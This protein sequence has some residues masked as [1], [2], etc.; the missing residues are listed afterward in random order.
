M[1][2]ASSASTRYILMGLGV[3]EFA[4]GLVAAFYG[5]AEIYVFYFFSEGGR[6]AYPGFGM[7]SVWFAAL[8]A[9][10][11]A[12]YLLAAAL[13]PLGYATLRRRAWAARA[14]LVLA[15]L[16]LLLGILASVLVLTCAATVLTPSELWAFRDR[17]AIIGIGLA[18]V[19]VILPVLFILLFTRPATSQ[20]LSVRSPF[21]DWLD[22]QPLPL[23]LATIGCGLAIIALHL[24]VFAQVFWPMFGTLGFGRANMY[25]I[26]VTIV[27]LGLVMVGLARGKRLALWGAA[28]VFA[29]LF[30]AFVTTFWNHDLADLLA[31]MDLPATERAWVDGARL[32]GA[33]FMLLASGLPLGAMLVLLFLGRRRFLRSPHLP[34]KP[35]HPEM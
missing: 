31:A 25:P 13:L 18:V 34:L 23:L 19:A 24:M 32:P 16:W 6:F 10:N 9:H 30:L 1:P 3:V 15:W 8:V 17:M 27:A 14:T 5:P 35:V 29:V 28:A 2:D 20:V 21:G 22:E 7:G 4:I 11:L 33:P 12:Y 26:V